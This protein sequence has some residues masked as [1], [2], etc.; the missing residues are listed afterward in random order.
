MFELDEALDWRAALRE[1][2]KAR[3]F[4]QT[5]L[6]RDASL[7]LSALKQYETGQRHPSAEA[8]DAIIAALGLTAEQS[9]P[10]RAGAG[11]APDMKRI[12]YER[13]GPYELSD[14]QEQA[15][16]Y[17]WPAFVTN[18]SA[19]VLVANRAFFRVIGSDLATL[20][21][22]DP[23]YRNFLSVA[24][25][26][27]FSDRVKNYDESM[28]FFI[29]L[30]KGEERWQHNLER[31]VPLLEGPMRRFLS[32]DPAYVSRMVRLYQ[33]AEPVRHT[34][35]V[36]S[37]FVWELEDGRVVTFRSMIHVADLYQE[38]AWHDWLPE[39]A[40]DHAVVESLSRGSR[41]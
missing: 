14:L 5:R 6:A 21:R 37:R 12:F 22:E 3:G 8:L 1:H 31:P 16:R 20:F 36:D 32:G 24:S 35:R 25:D 15:E 13:L 9:G 34:T 30:M 18:I 11:Y 28:R 10:I 40:A 33:E 17:N 2:R 29:G 27:R 4:T 41:T 19:D 7:S 23:T 26:A 38:L 39:T